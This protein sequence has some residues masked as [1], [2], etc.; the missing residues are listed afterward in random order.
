MDI[1]PGTET[2][3]LSLKPRRPYA[4]VAKRG[5]RKCHQGAIV[6]R[7]ESCLEQMLSVLSLKLRGQIE[8]LSATISEFHG[9]DSTNKTFALEALQG[10]LLIKYRC[11]RPVSRVSRSLERLKSGLDFHLIFYMP[12]YSSGLRDQ[13]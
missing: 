13:S 7:F 11:R 2:L 6:C 1:K 3:V 5:N 10:Y 12:M 9:K 4:Q 8:Q